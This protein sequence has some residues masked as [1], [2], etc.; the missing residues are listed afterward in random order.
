MNYPKQPGSYILTH[1][2]TG[3]F[4]VGSSGNIAERMKNHRK[5][6]V[7]GR[8]HAVA[9]QAVFTSW[10]D[11]HVN[12]VVAQTREEALEQEQIALN[13]V[14]GHAN[15]CN[16]SKSAYFSSEHLHSRKASLKSAET[17]RGRT[18]SREVVERQ[19]AGRSKRVLIDDIEYP[20]VKSAASALGVTPGAVVQGLKNGTQRHQTWRYL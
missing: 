10:L 14:H 9:L 15:C 5:E 6:L 20:S 7:K 8:H 12:F 17:R 18:A 19:A 3:M 4:Y 1:V 11:I 13:L 2:P 16:T